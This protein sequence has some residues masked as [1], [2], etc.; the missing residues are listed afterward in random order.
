V[1]RCWIEVCGVEKRVGKDKSESKNE[2]KVL[3]KIDR[4][5]IIIRDSHFGKSGV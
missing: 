2:S 1:I 4:M 3:H 5:K